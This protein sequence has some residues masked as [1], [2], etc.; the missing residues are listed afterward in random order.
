MTGSRRACALVVLALLAWCAAAQD[1]LP[2]DEGV[3]PE[4]TVEDPRCA[5]RYEWRGQ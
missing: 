5:L 1:A 2:L 4:T 3:P